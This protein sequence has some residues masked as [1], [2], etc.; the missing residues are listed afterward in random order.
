MFETERLVEVGDDALAL[1]NVA[2]SIGAGL[3][4]AVAGWAIG[5]AA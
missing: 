3:A 4:A 1:V 2:L 5:A